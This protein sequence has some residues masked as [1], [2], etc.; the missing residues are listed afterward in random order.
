MAVKYVT[1]YGNDRGDVARDLRVPVD[2]VQSDG[3]VNRR[4][5]AVSLVRDYVS[6][7]LVVQLDTAKDKA[8][9]DYFTR[10]ADHD[11]YRVSDQRPP[12]DIQHVQA[13]FRR[14]TIEDFSYKLSEAHNPA[15]LKQWQMTLMKARV[16]PRFIRLVEERITMLEDSAATLS[17]RQKEFASASAAK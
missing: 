13:T 4:A 1:Y 7:R 16:N 17:K 8:V 11:Y 14:A 2:V 5:V 15:E 12:A 9:L 10:Y 6:G 3:Q